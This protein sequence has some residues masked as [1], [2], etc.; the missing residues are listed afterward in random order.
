MT[1]TP[2]AGVR[3]ERR[4][5]LELP[6]LTALAIRSAG[7]SPAALD[8]AAFTKHCETLVR[9]HLDAGRA[10]PEALLLR[11]AEAGARLEARGVPRPTLGAFG[12]YDPEVAFGPIHRALPVLLI[13][14][15]LAPH[16]HLPPHNHTPAY[17]V[18][19]CLEGACRVEHFE[20]A[21]DAPAPGEQGEFE[22]RRTRAQL[23][24]PVRRRR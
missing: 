14:W 16:A 21:G 18:S 20:I 19:L 9:E 7:A 4:A 23:L 8:F 22:L 5:F 1:T 11:L 13:Q 6:A 24:R 10:Q 17:V 3:L 15:R 12:G 2:L